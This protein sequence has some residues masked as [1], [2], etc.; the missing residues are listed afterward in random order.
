[1]KP[2]PIANSEMIAIPNFKLEEY[3]GEGWAPGIYNDGINQGPGIGMGM[4]SSVQFIST[5]R[6]IFSMSSTV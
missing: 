2:A 6:N 5:F 4:S 1:M 3:K